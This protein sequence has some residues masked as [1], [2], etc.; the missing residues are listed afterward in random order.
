MFEDTN[1]ST[2]MQL[3]TTEVVARHLDTFPYIINLF[4]LFIFNEGPCYYVTTFTVNNKQ[5]SAN[6]YTQKE[7]ILM[8]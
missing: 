4:G 7:H 5:K 8:V 2:N 6:V 3:F 1:N